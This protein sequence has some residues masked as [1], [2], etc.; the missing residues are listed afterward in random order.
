MSRSTKHKRV[1]K[2]ETSQ[3]I[4]II[5]CTRGTVPQTNE[6][7]NKFF[8]RAR[9]KSPGVF[10]DWKSW[11]VEVLIRGILITGIALANSDLMPIF[12]RQKQPQDQH[13]ANFPHLKSGSIPYGHVIAVATVAPY[14]IYTI[15]AV[16]FCINSCGG[17]FLSLKVHLCYF[18]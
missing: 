13:E 15:Y 7:K 1:F 16:V 9:W 11:T 12:E 17:K 14:V 3:G 6:K 18:W 4:I 8:F 5:D 10:A 2:W